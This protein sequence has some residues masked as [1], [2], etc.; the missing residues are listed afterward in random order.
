MFKFV[1]KTSILK[2]KQKVLYVDFVIRGEQICSINIK[3]P[4][5]TDEIREKSTGGGA[6]LA[7]KVF[8]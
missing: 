8:R 3:C 6:H 7:Q 1:E 4:P 2:T 5:P